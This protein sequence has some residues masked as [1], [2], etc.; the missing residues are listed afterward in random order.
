[1]F[2]YVDAPQLPDH[3]I[4]IV[5]QVVAEYQGDTKL[6][7]FSKMQINDGIVE[8]IEKLYPDLP[9]G[10]GVSFDTAYKYQGLAT[11]TMIKLEGEV[12]DW[13]KQNV[14]ADIDGLH[15]QLIDGDYVFPHIDMLRS[16]VWNYTIDTGDAVTCF[17]KPKPEYA[18]LK[19]V[20]RT[21]VPYERVDRTDTFKIDAHRWHELDVSQIHG[22]EEIKS[23]RL[24]LSISFIV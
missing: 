4:N 20:P 6:P 11:F 5:R 19:L 22:V 18:N 16:R 7:E 9:D 17:Y 21:Y 12:L 2:K 14:C 13:I 8:Q 1:M 23:P 15:I 10:L 3:L 24:A